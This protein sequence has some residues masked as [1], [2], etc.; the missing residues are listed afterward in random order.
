MH[1]PR[2]RWNEDFVGLNM[3]TFTALNGGEQKS[4]EAPSGHAANKRASSEDR[5]VDQPGNQ[6]PKLPESTSTQREPWSGP[7]GERT[8]LQPTI[9][10]DFEGAHKRKRSNSNERLRDPSS[11]RDRDQYPQSESRDAYGLSPRDRDYRSFGEDSR[12]NH[13]SW[14]SQ[15]HREEARQPETQN[16][17]QPTHSQQADDR[18][19]GPHRTA[20]SPV[21]P[22]DGEYYESLTPDYKRSAMQLPDRDAIIQSDPKK[23]KRNFSN[24]TK[25]GCLT[26]RR[27]KK[28]CDET[29]P[30][31]TNCVRGGFLC[32]GYANQRGYPKLETKP[33]AVPLESKDPSYVPPGAY[34][35]PQQ[36]SYPNPP[37]S[38]SKREGS[39]PA[40]RGPSL[41]IDPPQGR[42]LN[43]ENRPTLSTIPNNAS[44]LSPPDGK[45][46]SLSPAYTNAANIYPTPISAVSSTMQLQ[47]PLT[48]VERPKEYQ[49]VPPLHDLTRTSESE[50]PQQQHQPPLPQINILHTSRA[51]SPPP[52]PPSTTNPQVA[53]QLALSHTQ[54]P[55][56]RQRT[57]KEEML[58]GRQYYPFD[59]ELVLERQ[60]C[61]AACWRFNN[62]TN[63]NNG[64]SA[65]ERSRLFREILNPKEPINISPHQLSPVTNVGRVGQEVVVEAPFTCDYGYNIT[66]GNNVFI[67]RNCTMLDPMEITIGD[68][69]YIGPNVSLYG[70]T[71]FTDPKKRMGSKSPQ[72]GKSIT[73]E[74][75]VWIGGGVTILPGKTIGK[76]ATVGAGAVVVDNVPRYTIVQGNPATVI[77]GVNAT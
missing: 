41:R 71:L 34:G 59:N 39:A 35:M 44:T 21:S 70:A 37:A 25:T 69:C 11:A 49:R 64:V 52:Q 8:A 29:K 31:C 51:S 68:N 73:I 17:S 38:A 47:T 16:T 66:I 43:D 3:A 30:E 19:G 56:T 20:T 23:R 33:A 5:S 55:I 13:E 4:P 46:S 76:G 53:A 28:K 14:Y 77:S 62:S 60:R 22:D 42:P 65:I 57:Q 18:I 27:R 58:I 15:Q 6:E 63:P 10:T 74:A 72:I 7:S 12:E 9:Y 54:Y 48:S 1:L 50:P 32:K 61:S 67:G 45:L 36:S 26:C 2:E 24:R 75:D 40:Y